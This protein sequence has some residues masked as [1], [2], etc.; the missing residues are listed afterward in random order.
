MSINKGCEWRTS[1]TLS[2]PFIDAGTSFL[3]NAH[4]Q[5]VT[6]K[7]CIYGAQHKGVM[8]ERKKWSEVWLHIKKKDNVVMSVDR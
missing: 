2:F 1:S 8:A 4:C 6:S 7:S 3:T 5:T